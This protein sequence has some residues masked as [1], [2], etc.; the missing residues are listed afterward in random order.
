MGRAKLTKT[1]A[2]DI[3]RSKGISK[4]STEISKKYGVSEKAVRDIWKGRTWSRETWPLDKSRPMHLKK[5]GRPIG[6]KDANPRKQQASHQ[7]V[8]L[9]MTVDPISNRLGVQ[10][11]HDLGPGMARIVDFLTLK[12]SE[13]N[14]Q[15]M[16]EH[17]SRGDHCSVHQPPLDEVLHMRDQHRGDFQDP[18]SHDWEVHCQD[19]QQQLRTNV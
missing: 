17:P 15:K 9:S 12:I 10:Q 13:N 19:F 16:P 8:K 7:A 5:L 1:E 4:G 6:S 2:L 14:G 11:G 18:F 3:F